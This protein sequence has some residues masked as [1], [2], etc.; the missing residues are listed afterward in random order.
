MK[1][2]TDSFCVGL[3]NEDILTC[4][5][6]KSTGVNKKNNHL[7]LNPGERHYDAVNANNCVFTVTANLMKKSLL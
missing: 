7:T 4:K 5:R 1:V 3:F 6:R 2:K